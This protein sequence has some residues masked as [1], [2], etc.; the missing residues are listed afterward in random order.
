MSE[1]SN[2]KNLYLLERNYHLFSILK[3][4]LYIML[5]SHVLDYILDPKNQLNLVL[6]AIKADPNGFLV[7][8]KIS[9]R[10]KT[11][12]RRTRS[13]GYWET[14]WGK[15]YLALEED[16]DLNSYN[17][18]KF[19]RR[20]RVPFPV[21]NY[22]IDVC[23]EKDVFEVKRNSLIP[24]EIK[25]M[26]CLR[27]LGRDC[28]AD[29]IAETLGIGE[30]SVYLIFKQFVRS[31]S[32]KCYH[33]YVYFPTGEELRQSMQVYERLGLPGCLGS[34][35]GTKIEWDKCPSEASNLCSGKEK[36]PTLGFQC[37]VNHSRQIYHI[38]PYFV[39]SATDITMFYWD[40]L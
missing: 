36:S 24:I 3:H 6:E 30:S 17:H 23:K 35:D 7:L 8:D 40:P 12:I 18:R 25:L 31:F 26:I 39:G 11:R 14:T 33:D 32:S 13:G 38:S 10:K 15:A 28:C 27:I 22:L 29:D 1:F 4:C 19:R 16:D 21:F 9:Y 2:L 20:F 37:I 34:L 5:S